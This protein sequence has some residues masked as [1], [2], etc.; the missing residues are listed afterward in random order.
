MAKLVYG[1][2]KLYTKKKYK[3]AEKKIKLPRK[4][5]GLSIYKQRG[6][7]LTL[8]WFKKNPEKFKDIKKGYGSKNHIQ[9]TYK[10]KG[11][12]VERTRVKLVVGKKIVSRAY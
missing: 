6:R 4:R 9:K 5:Y 2:R 12:G 7:D 11:N 3:V 10:L 1:Y 8:S